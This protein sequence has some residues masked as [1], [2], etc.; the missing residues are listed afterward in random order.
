M[1]LPLKV[2]TWIQ[3]DIRYQ[4]MH[5][6]SISIDEFVI[7]INSYWKV[8]K[9]SNLR[10]HRTKGNWQSSSNKC[11]LIDDYFKY[12]KLK[13]SCT[14]ESHG[15]VIIDWLKLTS[16]SADKFYSRNVEP[17]MQLKFSSWHLRLTAR[18]KG[19]SLIQLQS[20][21][22]NFYYNLRSIPIRWKSEANDKIIN[23]LSAIS[24]TRW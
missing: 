19:I 15:I 3:T 2:T 17:F 1:E 9:I 23:L 24:A 10:S 20:A 22:V 16:L 7:F 6:I 18:R 8:I 11:Y 13:S 12:F 5:S 21:G 4:Q 14:L